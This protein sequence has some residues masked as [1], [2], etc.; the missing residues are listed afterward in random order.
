M[1]VAEELSDGTS[2]RR[3]LNVAMWS[4]RHRQAE[5]LSQGELWK[6]SRKSGIVPEAKRLL[7]Q[8]SIASCRQE[9]LA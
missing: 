3:Q 6:S 4:I 1:T 7:E 9:M 2:G 5:S 8:L